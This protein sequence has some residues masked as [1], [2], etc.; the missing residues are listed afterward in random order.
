MFT[1]NYFGRVRTLR[2]NYY[3]ISI[4][5]DIKMSKF[6]LCNNV[7]FIYMPLNVIR[8][9]IIRVFKTYKYHILKQ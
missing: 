1:E 2:S 4:I 3:Y 5:F 6:T 7:I 8:K 9:E